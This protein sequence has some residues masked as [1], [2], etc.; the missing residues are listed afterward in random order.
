MLGWV[1]DIGGLDR[2]E[3]LP[4]RNETISG[5]LKSRDDLRKRLDRRK[6]PGMQQDDLGRGR[7]HEQVVL[8]LLRRHFTPVSGIVGPQNELV[9]QALRDANCRIGVAAVRRADKRAEGGIVNELPQRIAAVD[10]LVAHLRVGFLIE[11]R[12]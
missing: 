4:D 12:M 11:I 9:P 5:G 3:K 7:V 10:D 8:D 6:L 1:V 2:F